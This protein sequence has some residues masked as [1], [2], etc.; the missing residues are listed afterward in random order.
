MIRTLIAVYGWVFALF[1]FLAYWRTSR[2]LQ[3][4]W[5]R[6]EEYQRIIADTLTP[7]S[8]AALKAAKKGF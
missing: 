3:R 7:P 8:L 4:A 5:A 1:C 2:A 6:E